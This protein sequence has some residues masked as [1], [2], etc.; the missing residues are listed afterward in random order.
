MRPLLLSV[1]GNLSGLANMC[2]FLLLTNFIAAL[3]ALQIFRGDIGEDAF[4]N[5]SHLW[6]GFLAMY[7]VLSSENWTDVLYTASEA[8]TPYKQTAISALFIV[9]WFFFA[10]FILIQLFIAVINENFEV[11]EEI[12]HNQ[13][14][15]RFRTNAAPAAVGMA[16][17]DRLN[18]YRY[19]KAS[20]ESIVVQNLPQNLV[21]P[22]QRS[23]IGNTSGTSAFD[24][25]QQVTGKNSWVKRRLRSLQA[26]FVGEEYS[27]DV[28][29]KNMRKKHERESVASDTLDENEKHLEILA[30]AVNADVAREEENANDALF[31]QRAQKADFINAHPSYDN[32]LWILPQSNRLRDRKSVV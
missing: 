31:E 8:E 21:Q 4:M 18:P 27:D 22:I 32:A 10:N 26:I 23:L 25:R 12:K 19:F 7:Q 1:F 24:K 20:P 9:G 28:P 29:M 6:N 14:F 30:A 16:W 17:V 5:F 3:F 13:Q 11:A 15:E 2:L